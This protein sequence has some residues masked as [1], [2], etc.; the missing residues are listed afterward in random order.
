MDVDEHE[1]LS[2]ITLKTQIKV[3]EYHLSLHSHSR[4]FNNEQNTYSKMS[5]K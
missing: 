3:Q 1:R 4:V 2:H 5:E